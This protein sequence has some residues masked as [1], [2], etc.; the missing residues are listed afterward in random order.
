MIDINPKISHQQT[1]VDAIELRGI[2]L[3][4]GKEVEIKLKPAEIDNGIK[5]IPV[6]YTHL[7]AHET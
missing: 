2:G 3:H 1:I 4:S 5:F 6:S 7:R